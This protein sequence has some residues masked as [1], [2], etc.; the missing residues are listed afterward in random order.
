MTTSAPM[1]FKNARIIDPSRGIDEIGTLIVAKGVIVAAGADAN[2]QG[3]PDGASVVDCQGKAIIPGL[4]DMRVHIGEPGGEHKETIESAGRAAAA[5]GV[6]SIV[7]MPDTRPVID[8]VAL[9]EFIL[10][11]ARENDTVRVLPAAALTLG[12]EGKEM[13]EIGNLLDAGAVMFTNG[14]KTLKN[15]A[16]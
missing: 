6:T 7:M 12:L 1:V 15:S 4:I 10:R 11:T 8:D 3:T 2:N 16:V 5:G 14:R 13:S 9:V